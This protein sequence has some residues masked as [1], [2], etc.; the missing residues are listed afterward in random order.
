MNKFC[1]N[2][3][4]EIDTN[5]KCCPNCGKEINLNDMNKRQ[6]KYIPSHE[7]KTIVYIIA[8]CLI[9][10]TAIR[11]CLFLYAPDISN[12]VSEIG[13]IIMQ[14]VAL[15]LAIYG[16]RKYPNNNTIHVIFLIMILP[17]IFYLL[18]FFIFFTACTIS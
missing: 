14:L 4:T 13:I 10:T 11:M 1:T 18:T 2:C 3:G 8:I 9:F 12:K 16:R 7:E 17:I 15:I 6:E 5:W